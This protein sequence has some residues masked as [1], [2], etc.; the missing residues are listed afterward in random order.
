MGNYLRLAETFRRTAQ[1]IHVLI[2]NS[3]DPG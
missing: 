2:G 3:G 1:G